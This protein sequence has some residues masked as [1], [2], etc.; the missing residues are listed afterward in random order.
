L[1]T[2]KLLRKGP[3]PGQGFSFWWT[4]KVDVDHINA[5]VSLKRFNTSP[6]SREPE[7]SYEANFDPENGGLRQENAFYGGESI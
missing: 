1:G 7:V 6:N 5:E 2:P 3:D 4:G